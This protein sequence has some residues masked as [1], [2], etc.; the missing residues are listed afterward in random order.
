MDSASLYRRMTLPD[1]EWH[2]P[3]NELKN[4]EQSTQPADQTRCINIMSAL[5]NCII[6]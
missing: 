2:Q 3:R 4:K 6:T 5:H 1:F